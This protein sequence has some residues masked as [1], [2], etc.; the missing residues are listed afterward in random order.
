MSH[1]APLSRPALALLLLPLAGTPAAAQSLHPPGATISGAAHADITP[2]GF[3]AIANL[4]PG[5]VPTGLDIPTVG[6][7]SSGTW[8]LCALG[9]Y[10]YELSNGW[11]D[12]AIDSASLTPQS[13]Y[14]QLDANLQIGVNSSADPLNLYIEALCIGSTCKG[15]VTPFSATLSTTLALQ[16]TGSGTDRRLDA[17]VGAINVS[18]SLSSSNIVISDCW[19]GTLESVLGI[20]G[21]S[22]F[23]L[24]LPLVEDQ[25]DSAVADFGPEIEALIEDAFSSLTIE[26]ELDLGGA[27]ATLNLYPSAVDI[28]TSG[29]R[30][31]MDG[32]MTAVEPADCVADYDP[33]G[34]L[35]TSNAA[36]SIG[37][38]PSGISPDYHAGILLSDDFG[39]QAL[40][41]LWRGGLLCYTLDENADIGVPITTSLLGLL[42]GDAFDELLPTSQPMVLQTRPKAAPTLQF[43]G[44]H[45]LGVQVEQ[46][47]L[48]FYGELDG[49]MA[50][51]L[52]VDLDAVAGVDLELDGA[53]GALAL[54]V[55]LSGEDVTPSVT[56]NEFAPEASGE[57][58]AQ[59][60][61]VFDSLV[62]TLI[63]GLVGDLAFNLPSFEGYGLTSLQTSAAGSAGDWLGAY[64]KLGPVS[65][66]SAG[67]DEGGGCDMGC[68]SGS[69][70]PG[71]GWLLLGLPLAL[72]GLRRR[73]V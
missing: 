13:G 2:D 68:A 64:A 34:S 43:A 39:N 25:L 69:R 14:L 7:S 46:L 21:L 58:E 17:Q 47:G 66:T 55:A 16:V 11:V 48:E 59:F 57:I 33:G 49:R 38:A 22:I 18:H 1:P 71:S 3:K 4:L 30:V 51:L 35:K 70:A 73:P 23:D 56:H 36:P 40:Y 24:I 42:A 12:I 5:L 72:A 54:N 65:Y 67:C 63:G 26:Q 15:Y 9:G 19:I 37:S 31:T 20:F 53:T 62:G 52:A 32:G 6:D 28:Q 61:G 41:S 60:S 44:E 8:G 50:Q 10:E 27:Q 29:V 45:D